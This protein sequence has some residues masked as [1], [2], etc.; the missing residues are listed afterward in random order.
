MFTQHGR[1]NMYRLISSC[2][3]NFFHIS[4]LVI[5]HQYSQNKKCGLIKIMLFISRSHVGKNLIF[6]LHIHESMSIIW[7]ITRNWK[8]NNRTDTD[9]KIRPLH[10]YWVFVLLYKYVNYSYNIYIHNEIIYY[11]LIKPIFI[12]TTTV[13]SYKSIYTGIWLAF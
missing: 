9:I 12:P 4:A 5:F 7:H 13:N 10:S 11:S 3:Y 1:I 6:K 2:S 8:S